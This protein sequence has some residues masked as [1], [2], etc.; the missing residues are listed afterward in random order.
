[1]ASEV[2]AYL[3]ARSERTQH[4]TNSDDVLKVIQQLAQAVRTAGWRGIIVDGVMMPVISEPAPHFDSQRWPS[5]E[6]IIN[7]ILRSHELDLRVR[8]LW[9]Q[10]PEPRR[11]DLPPP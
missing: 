7:M 5:S 6:S 4:K 9:N 2:E 1:M 10:V 3:D 11:R 8:N